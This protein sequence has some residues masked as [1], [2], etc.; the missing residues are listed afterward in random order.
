MANTP[1][2]QYTQN[3]SNAG[4]IWK[5]E[6]HIGYQLLLMLKIVIYVKWV[7]EWIW[8]YDPFSNWGYIKSMRWCDD[9]E[10]P[11]HRDTM[12]CSSRKSDKG[13]FTCI[14]GWAHTTRHCRYLCLGSL[15]NQS[16]G[17]GW[18]E[19]IAKQEYEKQEYDLPSTL[20]VPWEPRLYQRC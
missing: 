16:W 4:K 3:D 2:Q 18:E 19:R 9:D 13:S 14:M 11:C 7:S 12:P 5:K 8:F 1:T 17:T 6:N 20:K 10:Q 15:I